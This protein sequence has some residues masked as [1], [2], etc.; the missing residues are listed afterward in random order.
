MN[1]VVK[2]LLFRSLVDV[3]VSV[4]TVMHYNLP[5]C[6]F[7]K[8]YCV[9]GRSVRVFSR[10]NLCLSSLTTSRIHGKIVFCGLRYV[11]CFSFNILCGLRSYGCLR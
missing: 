8:N 3:Y 11:M 9:L 4:V 6:R 10:L 5:I 2:N 7:V 1:T